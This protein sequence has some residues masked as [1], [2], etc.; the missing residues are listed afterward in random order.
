MGI[1]SST[2]AAAHNDG[3]QKKAAG[4]LDTVKSKDWDKV[5]EIQGW[6]DSRPFDEY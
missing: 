6:L 5:R 4:L 3:L 1:F 2:A